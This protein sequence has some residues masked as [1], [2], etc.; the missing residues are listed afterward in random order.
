MLVKAL[1]SLPLNSCGLHGILS[2]SC[3]SLCQMGF[4]IFDVM[5]LFNGL[6]AFLQ[7]W[8]IFEHRVEDALSIR[9]KL[10]DFIA[11]ILLDINMFVICVSDKEIKVAL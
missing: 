7:R 5:G 10:S 3:N 4:Q 2:Q 6:D 1:Q 8:D 9:H 11:Q